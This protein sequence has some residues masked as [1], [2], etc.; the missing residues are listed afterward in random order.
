[1]VIRGLVRRRAARVG[2][3]VVGL[4]VALSSGRARASIVVALDL[5]ELVRQADHIAIV[6]VTDVRS[7][8][9]STGSRIFTTVDL[10]VVEVWKGGMDPAGKAATHI[11]ILQPGGTVGDISMTIA[12]LSAFAPGERAVV[13]LRGTTARA[14]PV[15]MAQGKRAMRFEARAARWMATGADLRQL[16]LVPKPATSSPV[17]PPPGGVSP[18]VAALAREVPV[19]ELSAEVKRLVGTSAR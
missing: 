11:T 17:L 3:V 13:F 19:D 14:Q 5:P 10:K 12:G 1:M 9:D 16:V 18:A 8:W 2:V 4:A 15:G 7:A 6:D